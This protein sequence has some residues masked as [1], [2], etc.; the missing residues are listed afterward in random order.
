MSRRPQAPPAKTAELLAA[1][2]AEGLLN[3]DA[4]L[5]SPARA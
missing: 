1:A 3:H 4:K 5:A 2:H